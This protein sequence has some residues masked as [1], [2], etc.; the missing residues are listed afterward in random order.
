MHKAL[1]SS[2]SIKKNER[3]LGWGN[4]KG[5]GRTERTGGKARQVSPKIRETTTYK[6]Y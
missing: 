5:K 3:K 6:C 2:S 1:S 4:T